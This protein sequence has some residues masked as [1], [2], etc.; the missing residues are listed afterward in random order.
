MITYW[1]VDEFIGYALCLFIYFGLWYM[2][3]CANVA[4]NS[5]EIEQTWN[6]KHGRSL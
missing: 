1:D 4:C 3:T 6:D 5:Y 2:F